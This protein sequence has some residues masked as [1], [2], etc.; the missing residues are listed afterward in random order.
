MMVDR[1][2]TLIIIPAFNEER[3]IGSVIDDLRADGPHANIL[4]ID[5]GSGD[6]TALIAEEKGVALI[7]LPY[8]LGIGGAVQTGYKY[9]FTKGYRFC[10]QVDADGQHRPDQIRKI[11]SP[12][13]E[14]RA[15]MV[16]GS[17]YLETSST[18]QASFSRRVGIELLARVVSAIIGQKFTDTTSGFRA[19][20]RHVIEFCREHYP[21][22]YPE[23]ESLVALKRSGFAVVEVPV[24]M[25][26]RVGGSS[27]ITALRAIYY[28]VKVLLA[29]FIE[30][31]RKPVLHHKE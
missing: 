31:L 20:N 26:E 14:K 3:T 27:S 1:H 6:R 16:I 22:D 11:L 4:V 7:R 13:T 15:D 18:Y 8:N 9:A 21:E 2:D 19:H 30:L 28:M 24:L 17:R 10:V 25:K 29:V 5:D 12:I 23:V